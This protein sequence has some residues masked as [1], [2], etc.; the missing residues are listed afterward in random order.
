MQKRKLRIV[1]RIGPAPYLGVCEGCNQQFRVTYGK[2]FTVEDATAVIQEQFDVHKCK[3]MDSSQNA[4]RI[5]QE[6]TKNK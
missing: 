4:L 3:P 5:V 2:E 6:A 1:K